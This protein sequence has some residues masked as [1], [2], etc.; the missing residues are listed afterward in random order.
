[1]GSVTTYNEGKHNPN[2]LHIRRDLWEQTVEDVKKLKEECNK[3][4]YLANF[5]FF[6][7]TTERPLLLGWVGEQQ[8]VGRL[9]QLEG[10][11]ALERRIH[12]LCLRV[13]KELLASELATMVVMTLSDAGQELQHL[14]AAK[15]QMVRGD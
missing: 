14:R 2:V 8:S 5:Y 4:R 3:A 7:S 13:E 11:T 6:W 12:D 10:A 9:M 15:R 1:M